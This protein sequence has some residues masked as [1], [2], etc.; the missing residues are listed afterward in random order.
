MASLESHLSALLDAHRNSNAEWYTNRAFPL[1][2]ESKRINISFNANEWVELTASVSGWFVVKATGSK[3]SLEIGTN[4]ENE[5]VFGADFSYVRGFVP[6]RKGDLLRFK[7]SA[8]SV[9]DQSAYIIP[10]GG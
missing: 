9:T 3:T 10:V 4:G 6:C 8:T 5:A 1:A 7:L 2:D